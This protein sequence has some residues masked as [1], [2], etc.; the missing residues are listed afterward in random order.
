MPQHK[1]NKKMFINGYVTCALWSSTDDNDEPMDSNYTGADIDQLT[2]GKM[3]LDCHEFYN[4]NKSL[5]PTGY[6]MSSAGHDFWLTR[7][8]HGA[9]FW[10]KDEL[11]DAGEALT[12]KCHGFPQVDLYVGDDGKIYA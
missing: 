8:G 4:K 1:E 3:V 7:N 2:Y 5:F 9:G 11:G 12:E 6:S 10:D